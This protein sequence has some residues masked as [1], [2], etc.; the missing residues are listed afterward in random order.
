MKLAIVHDYLNQF[1]GAERV[2]MA[3]HE[4][5]P[6]APIF[7]SIYD[8]EKMP[9]EF[10]SMDIRTT[11][12]QHLPQVMARYKAYLPLYPLAFSSID[13]KG[14]D[15]IL[16]SSSAFAKG[17][18]KPAN[19]LHICYC[20]NPMRFVWRYDDYIREEPLPKM[21]KAILPIFLRRMKMWDVKTSASVD[22]FVSISIVVAR[23]ILECYGRDSTV[24][25]PPVET[26]KFN[27]AP[28]VGDHYL[29]VS[30]LKPYKKIELAVEA[31]NKMKKP[32][33][34]IGGGDFEGKLRA[35][36]GS[37]IEFL[38]K[39]DDDLLA[40]HYSRCRALVFPGEEDFG[41]VPVEAMASGR[42]VVAYGR[43]GALETVVDGQTGVFFTEP[44]ADRLIDAV[45]RLEEISFDPG[46]IRR[47]ALTFGK[48]LF[49]KKIKELVDV[50]LRE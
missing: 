42:P 40:Y 18:S 43:G 11:F 6:E 2:V 17:I 34:I 29:I 3:L 37:S 13:L 48:E 39:V 33:K 47:H 20:Y 21:V 31:F 49:K 35:M 7:T 25:Y 38:G 12:M 27:I 10:L 4:A 24:I 8:R 50:K 45:H 22:H 5:Y 15:C 44:T 46:S 16:S 28:E 9:K 19:S 30:R 14:F 41:I 36:A 26:E 23:R 1:G 32:L